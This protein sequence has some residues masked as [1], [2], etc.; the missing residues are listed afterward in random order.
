MQRSHSTTGS[1]EG[2]ARRAAAQVAVAAV[3]ASLLVVAPVPKPAAA[4]SSA[5][6][7][8][9]LPPS[10]VLDTRSGVGAPA[11]VVG[12]GAVMSFVV[13][14]R[15]GVPATD[16]SAV[17]LNMT[18]VAPTAGSYM[19]VW[20]AGEAMPTASNLN[21]SPG[22][23]VP[24]LVKVKVG[25]GGQ[26]SVFNAAGTV[27]VLADVAGWYKAGADPAEG[28]RY[29]A[30]SPS[31]I[32][33][34]RIGI[35]APAATVGPGGSVNL[36]VTGSGGVPASGVSAVAM[37]VTVVG[38][39][40]PSSY[41]TA[42]PTGET[43]PTASNLNYVAGDVVPNLVI[44][45]V[46]AGGAVSL[47]NDTG[48]THILSDVVGW[49]SAP[50]GP[51][52]IY[53]PLSPARILD[54]RT[55]NGA[56]AAP[57]G[58]GVPLELQ[59]TGRGGVP[60]ADVSAVVVNVTAVNP[61]AESYLTVWPTGEA[62]PTASNLNYRAGAV[63]PNL[64]IVKVGAGGRISLNNDAGQTQVIAD[65]VGW[66]GAPPPT[67]F[68]NR[69]L[70]VTLQHPHLF[71]PPDVSAPAGSRVTMTFQNP[72]DEVHTFTS[73]PVGVDRAVDPFQTITFSFTM[74]FSN[75]R[76]VC[77][78]HQSEGMVGTLTPTDS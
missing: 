21:Y 38:P 72:T 77:L 32:L 42:W 15:G 8:F 26:V 52:T 34:T 14:G 46:G 45:K 6:T 57:I 19:T 3:L 33:D 22:Q 31:R 53:A 18:V 29:N 5:G 75:T 11:G 65:V 61:T 62:R 73:P 28:A 43:R 2:G 7:F 54:T 55:G 24:N 64:V 20:P 40:A 76:Y 44:V 23:T 39:T 9:P 13:T 67:V 63:V 16:V 68:V 66:F 36:Q 51:G 12:P 48:Q 74:P 10:R 56:P 49:Y 1:R 4:A 59:V 58:A 25:A 37:N 30:L 17:V 47:Y 35:G 69:S 78:I 71:V 41:L 70:S 50:A 60:V 27:H